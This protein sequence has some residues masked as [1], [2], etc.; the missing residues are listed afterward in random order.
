MYQNYYKPEQDSM[1][2][3]LEKSS[4]LNSRSKMTMPT[5]GCHLTLTDSKTDHNLCPKLNMI[6]EL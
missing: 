2:N 5:K 4:D 3:K 6:T 1:T